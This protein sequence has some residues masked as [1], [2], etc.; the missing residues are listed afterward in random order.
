MYLKFTTVFLTHGEFTLRLL[1][2][3]MMQFFYSV[4]VKFS[5]GLLI[6]QFTNHIS[7]SFLIQVTDPSALCNYV[8]SNLNL[9]ELYIYK[10]HCIF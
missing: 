5:I 10:M 7:Q 2:F 3:C 1:L 4:S 6:F 9:C 8:Y